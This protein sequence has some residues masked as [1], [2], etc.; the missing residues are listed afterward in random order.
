MIQ[1]TVETPQSASGRTNGHTDKIPLVSVPYC[2]KGLLIHFH[3]EVAVLSKFLFGCD[4]CFFAIIVSTTTMG[5]TE[6]N[7]QLHHPE[8][9]N[10]KRQRHEEESIQVFVRVR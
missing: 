9:P 8:T 1:R 4:L 2:L 6:L 3:I 10:M 5:L 7:S